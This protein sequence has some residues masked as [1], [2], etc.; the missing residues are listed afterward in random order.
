MG[1]QHLA[2]CVHSTGASRFALANLV[3]GYGSENRYKDREHP[4]QVLA[5]LVPAG[6]YVPT[7][8]LQGTEHSIEANAS[9]LKRVL[10]ICRCFVPASKKSMSESKPKAETRQVRSLED[11]QCAASPEGLLPMVFKKLST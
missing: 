6:R 11:R 10:S 8:L 9:K 1:G 4:K 3:G 7:C 2:R 5:L